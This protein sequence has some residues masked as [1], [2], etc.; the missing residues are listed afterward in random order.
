MIIDAPTI[1]RRIKRA[2][3][4][5][6]WTQRQLADALGVNIKTVDNWEAGR[7]SPRNRL[8]ALEEVLGITL[9]SEPAQPAPEDWRDWTDAWEKS[10]LEDWYLDAETKRWLIESSRDARSQYAARRAR[11]AAEQEAARSRPRHGR[12]AG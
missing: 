5:R 3:E 12:S 7:T 10:V 11:L 1:G 2:R 9:D 8:G 4:R 6:R